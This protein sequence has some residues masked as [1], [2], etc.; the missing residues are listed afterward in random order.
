MAIVA[1]LE[2]ENTNA[3]TG[4]LTPL[5]QAG[6]GEKERLR[7]IFTLMTGWQ[8]DWLIVLGDGE[9]PLQGEAAS[10]R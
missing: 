1:A 7:G 2:H 10:R 9:S 4:S 3:M 8:S 5:P 6:E